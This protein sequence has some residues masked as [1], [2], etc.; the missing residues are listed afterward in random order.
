MKAQPMSQIEA[1]RI[2]QLAERQMS[3]RAG[4]LFWALVIAT[5]VVAVL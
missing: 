3:A 2:Q 1:D 4:C 5:F